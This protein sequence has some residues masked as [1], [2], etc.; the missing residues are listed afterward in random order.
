[1]N[2]KNIGWFL[3]HALCIGLCATSAEARG[4]D[5]LPSRGY[6]LSGEMLLYS[7]AACGLPNGLSVTPAN[8]RGGDASTVSIR[9]RADIAFAGERVA[10]LTSSALFDPASRIVITR[11]GELAIDGTREPSLQL[12]REPP[13]QF[14]REPSLDITHELRLDVSRESAFEFTREPPLDV[15]DLELIDSDA[16]PWTLYATSEALHARPVFRI[17]PQS[18]TLRAL[19]PDELVIAGEITL[20][21]ALSAEL[22]LDPERAYTIGAITIVAGSHPGAKPSAPRTE[23][24]WIATAPGTS[25]PQVMAPD[26]IVSGIGNTLTKNGTVGAIT[27]YSVSTTACNIGSLFAQWFGSFAAHPVIGTQIYRMKTVDGSTRFEQIGM[28]WLKHGFCAADAPGCPGGTYTPEGTCNYLGLF[29]MDTYDASLNGQQLN[30]SSRSEVNPFT[31]VYPFPPILNWGVT[32]DA[33]FKRTQVAN[34]DIDPSSNAGARYFGEVVYVTT[35]EPAENRYNNVS[36][37]EILLGAPTDTPPG[38]NLAFTGSTSSQHAAIEAWPANDTGVAMSSVDVPGDGRLI[39]CSKATRLGSSR[40][41]YEYALFDM[42]C[43]AGVRAFSVP[44]APSVHA[45]DFGFHDVSYHSGDP[46]D[47][48][49]WPASRNASSI[50]WATA[51]FATNPDAN[52]LRWNTLYNFRFDANAPPAS[53]MVTL[54]LFKTDGAV[55]V[56][57]Q[58]PAGAPS[59][60]DVCQPGT[61]VVARCPCLNPPNG[62]PRGCD[63]S[64]STGGAA[65]RAGGSASLAADTLAFATNGEKPSATSIVL[66][67]DAFLEGGAIFGQ[68][69]RCVG[70]TL[71]RLYVKT[72]IGGMIRAPEAGDLSVSARSSAL[73]DAIAP[74]TTRWYAVYYRDPIVLGGCDAASTFNMTQTLEVSWVF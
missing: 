38:S 59:A 57:A 12:T 8:T 56:S 47:G 17:A 13:F 71:E 50:D 18:L 24:R 42:N 46:F 32:G 52:A 45:V 33:I 3:F 15:G 64:S 22:G 19:S 28:S 58:V 68:G 1:M 14:T 37:R 23:P 44:A 74:G 60:I 26:V 2:M 53:G 51:L 35:D 70:G 40:W 4:S 25:G 30:L 39:L 29:A 54:G 48:T 61:G 10:E 7:R 49:D 43:D 31:G 11:N 66:Q 21:P 6:L 63:N 67:G 72:A 16:E 36:Y 55:T 9:A 73:G 65:L 69:V 41:H 5:P 20:H 34:A 27:A 62:A